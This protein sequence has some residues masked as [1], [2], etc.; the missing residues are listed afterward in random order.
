MGWPITNGKSSTGWVGPWFPCGRG[1]GALQRETILPTVRNPIARFAIDLCAIGVRRRVTTVRPMMS[2]SFLSKAFRRKSDSLPPWAALDQESLRI[3][4]AMEHVQDHGN[5]DTFPGGQS[6]RLALLLTARRQGL[7]TWDRAGERYELTSLGRERLGMRR[8]LQES[9][10]P[11]NLP[12]APAPA[13]PAGR[14]L[15]LGSGTIMAG[16]AGVAFGAAAMALLP[17]SSS[18]IPPRDRA[19]VATASKPADAG[20]APRPTQAQVQP[21]APRQEEAS[22][23]RDPGIPCLAEKCLETGGSAEQSAQRAGKPDRAADAPAP[24]P[25]PQRN[26]EPPKAEPQQQAGVHSGQAGAVGGPLAQQLALAAAVPA[27]PA[28]A[29]AQTATSQPAISQAPPPTAEANP[30]PAPKQPP[31]RRTTERARTHQAAPAANP[32]QPGYVDWLFR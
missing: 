2:M 6:E 32:E 17:G 20:N 16:I 5:L 7:V 27:P 31:P 11:M 15:T 19:A 3:S 1:G 30:A 28:P 21:P 23:A 10:G 4:A 12:P 9:G 26:P 13:A 24:A 29:P 18:K 8:A 14:F 22:V 25:A